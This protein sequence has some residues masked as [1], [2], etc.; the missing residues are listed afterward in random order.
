MVAFQSTL[1]RF[2]EDIAALLIL[3]VLLCLPLCGWHYSREG[4]PQ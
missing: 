3:A 2:V 1:D 4:R